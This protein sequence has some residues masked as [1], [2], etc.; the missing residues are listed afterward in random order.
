MF[1]KDFNEADQSI[2]KKE[3]IYFNGT[4]YPSTGDVFQEQL[5]FSLKA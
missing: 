1:M 3:P 2:D 5:I 4:S